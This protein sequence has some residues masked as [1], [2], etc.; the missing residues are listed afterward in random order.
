MEVES[1]QQ[2]RDPAEV[3][4][5]PLHLWWLRKWEQLALAAAE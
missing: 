5:A 2:V 3:E 1:Q 4:P